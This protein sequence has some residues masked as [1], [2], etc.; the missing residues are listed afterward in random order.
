MRTVTKTRTGLE[1]FFIFFERVVNMARD[2]LACNV[3]MYQCDFTS[4]AIQSEQQQCLKQ[5]H[6]QYK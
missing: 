1:C 3:H 4:I 2:F 5:S 6:K